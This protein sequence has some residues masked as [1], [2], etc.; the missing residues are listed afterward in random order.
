M[1]LAVF[2]SSSIGKAYGYL[3]F[4]RGSTLL[5]QPFN[6]EAL[7]LAGDV[8]P[9]ASDASFSFDP[10]LIAASASASGRLVYVSNPGM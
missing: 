1:A 5:A 4:L 10:P 2:A 7:Q 3:L 9:V 8:F 6:A